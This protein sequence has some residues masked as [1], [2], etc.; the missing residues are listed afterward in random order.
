MTL[1]EELEITISDD[2]LCGRPPND[3]AAEQDTFALTEAIIGDID[4]LEL[5][6]IS[7]MRHEARSFALAG[8][9]RSLERVARHVRK[10]REG[11]VMI[12]PSW[13][14]RG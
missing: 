4:L 8:S 13:N 14:T 3:P 9:R 10:T 1:R 6:D 7:V 2:A 5:S 12:V 11:L